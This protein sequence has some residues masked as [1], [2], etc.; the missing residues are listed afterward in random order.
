MPPT[1]SRAGWCEHPHPLLECTPPTEHKGGTAVPS[2]PRP[3]WSSHISSHPSVPE[4]LSGDPRI[5]QEG[6][7]RLAKGGCASQIKPKAET[8]SGAHDAPRDIERGARC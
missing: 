1:P 3:Q 6:K 4:L 8:T 2:P 5:N 7:L